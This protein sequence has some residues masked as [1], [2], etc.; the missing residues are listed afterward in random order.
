M[1]ARSSALATFAP[2]DARQ[3]V[4]DHYS[5]GPHRLRDALRRQERRELVDRQ[6][7]SVVRDDVGADPL[8]DDRIGHGDDGGHGDA[9]MREDLLF[10]RGGTD[11]VPAA[12]DEIGRATD[13]AEVVV[14]VDLDD[15][16]QVH[17]A[18]GPEQL[19]VRLVV[20]V[21]PG[22][23]ARSLAGTTTDT[24]GSDVAFVV[25]EETYVHLGKETP[26]R[27]ESLF[28][29]VDEGGTAHA[30]GFVRTVELED[31][32]VGAA[33][34]LGCRAERHLLAAAL[35]DAQRR[36]VG[37]REERRGEQHEDLRGDGREHGHAMTFDGLEGGRDVELLHQ[38]RLRPQHGG[39]EVTHPQA[40]P[41][42]RRDD[43][44]EDVVLSELRALAVEVLPTVL[45]VHHALGQAGGAR[46]GVDEEELV[47]A[48]GQAVDRGECVLEGG[49]HEVTS[50]EARGE[51]VVRMPHGEVLCDRRPEIAVLLGQA[52]AGM[53]PVLFQGQ[54]RRGSG[55]VQ[56][57]RGLASARPRTD[58]NRDHARAFCGDVRKV[59]RRTVRQQDS[60]WV[61]TTQAGAGESRRKARGQLV[62]LAPRERQ[63]VVA[64][65]G[66][67]VR[68]VR[69]VPR[70]ALR[71]RLVIPELQLGVLRD[72]PG[73]KN[74]EFHDELAFSA[75]R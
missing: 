75:M 36:D 28:D 11:V 56:E 10:D 62:V 15:V 71:D 2:A 38:D 3:L 47:R 68:L 17:P 61:T 59:R 72:D 1:S 54:Q 64:E 42:R 20:A 6:V 57:M 25:V 26:R 50:V 16:T 7:R 4:D 32:G 45:G 35:D 65:E 33:F 37:T 52:R 55:L 41:E 34:E 5:L 13:D 51:R 48:E 14:F 53:P 27:A 40:E 44:Q 9:G 74:I 63:V 39:G 30:S 18:V 58:P 46:R 19:R 49:D 8:A 66:D 31:A 43:D 70:N 29:R 12:N 69:R 21:V 73:G 67:V 22:R 24:L 23:D 60:E